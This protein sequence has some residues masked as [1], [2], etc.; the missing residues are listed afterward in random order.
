MSGFSAFAESLFE[1]RRMAHFVIGLMTLLL[2]YLGLPI[3]LTRRH[4]NSTTLNLQLDAARVIQ[5]E[6]TGN[7]VIVGFIFT[8][9]ESTLIP[10]TTGPL[11]PDT[12]YAYPGFAE[13]IS[14]PDGGILNLTVLQELER[15]ANIAKEHDVADYYGPLVSDITDTSRWRS[16]PS[17]QLSLIHE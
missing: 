16:I 13:G 3:G 4:R 10:D 6:F 9:T 15:K 7:G 17:G 14:S 5:D 1:R 12:M 8:V 11:D 2:S